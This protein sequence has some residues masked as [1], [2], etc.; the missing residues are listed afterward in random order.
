MPFSVRFGRDEGQFS[1]KITNN[2]LYIQ[3]FLLFSV[4]FFC[5]YF[6][7]ATFLTNCKLF[8]LFCTIC[9]CKDDKI[10]TCCTRGVNDQVRGSVFF[11]KISITQP[12][13]RDI[14]EQ[15]FAAKFGINFPYTPVLARTECESY[16]FRGMWRSGALRDT[17]A[18]A[19]CLSVILARKHCPIRRSELQTGL[20]VDIRIMLSFPI[21]RHSVPIPLYV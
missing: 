1:R 19:Y 5:L 14:I 13:S 8:Y 18:S 15:I 4:I 11:A 7:F 9:R 20:F 6:F 10:G 16:T 21:Y 17:G 12:F 3:V 2:S